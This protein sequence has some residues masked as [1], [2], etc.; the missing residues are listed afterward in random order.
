MLEIRLLGRPQVLL[1]GEAVTDWISDKARALL[2]YLV[3]TGGVHDRRTLAGLLWGEM[4]EQ[5]ALSNL[6]QAIYNL[7]QLVGPYLVVTNRSVE[8]DS[9]QAFELDLERFTV[10]TASRSCTLTD[11]YLAAAQFRGEFLE[12][13]YLTDCPEFEHWLLSERERIH[14]ETLG[15]LNRVATE[16]IARWDYEAAIQTLHRLL[17][18]APWNEADHRRLMLLLARTGRYSEA[19]AQ[20]ARCCQMLERELEVEPM[21][22]TQELYQRIRKA[23]VAARPPLPA[24]AVRT[25][26]RKSEIAL[27]DQVL[28]QREQ[29]LITIVGPAGAGKTHLALDIVRRHQLAYLHGVRYLPIRPLP[30]PATGPLLATLL[31]RAASLPLADQGSWQ[32]LTEWFAERELL[33]FLDG[34]D[35]LLPIGHELIRLLRDAPD[36]TLLV[37]ARSP[38]NLKQ[39]W[40]LPLAGLPFGAPGEGGERERAAAVALFAESASRRIPD[41]DLEAN[42][43]DVA[44]ICRFVQG[45]PRRILQAV[46]LLD[47]F[48]CGEIASILTVFLGDES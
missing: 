46:S 31:A 37:T 9:S 39:E 22:E 33:L 45:N 8:F 23:R 41:F 20:Y 44:E 10:A 43:I 24:S 38:L 27:L 47:R 36:L 26:G 6:R 15:I 7:Q 18:L 40:V 16:E 3:A 1:R 29:R 21:P 19:L 35:P 28:A 25:I 34:F 11:L 48:A 2:F 5:R 12:G 13:F 17:R 4:P 14:H 30:E 32:P 42:A